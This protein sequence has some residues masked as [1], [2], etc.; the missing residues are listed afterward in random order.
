MCAGVRDAANLS[1][2]LDHLL[3]GSAPESLLNTYQ[4]ER[5][6]SVITTIEFSMELGKIICV[7]DPEKAA[8]RDEE[9]SAAV[10][11]E[12]SEVPPLPGIAEGVV[13]PRAPYAG[14]LMAQG[15]VGGRPFDDVF[16]VG[17]RLITVE[18]TAHARQT[19]GLDWF[20]S[21][22]GRLVVLDRPDAILTRWFAERGASWALQ[23]PDFRLYGT[24]TSTEE[25]SE[26]LEALRHQLSVDRLLQGAPE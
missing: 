5:L 23:R 13:H 4:Q 10:G 19:A 12:P 26:L 16:G 21:L 1:W 11:P 9:L 24:A 2:K 20:E 15:N 8:T 14:E 3:G 22:G 18:N 25:A 6:P 7:S 17:W